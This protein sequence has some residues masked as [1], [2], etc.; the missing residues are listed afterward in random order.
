MEE[1]EKIDLKNA[2]E[3]FE[4][5]KTSFPRLKWGLL[6]GQM[7]SEEKFQIME[8]FI[9]KNIDVL[10]TTTVIEV[11]VDVSNASIMVV[12]HSERFGLS[13]LH[14]LRGRV[15]RGSEKSYCILILGDRVSK[16]S[17]I[18]ACIME[19]YSDGFHI[20]EEDLNLR[21][22]GEFFGTKQSG[23]I[24]FRIAHIIRDIEVLRQ[25]RRAAQMLVDKDPDLKQEPLLKQEMEKLSQIRMI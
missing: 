8:N 7:K 3:E 21:G 9:S 1:S 6:H 22:A 12:E 2:V 11:G 24:N 15:G 16:E 23:N 13:Q 10:V 20:A 25:A 14:Q 17:Y 5:L 19:K 4:K 18:R